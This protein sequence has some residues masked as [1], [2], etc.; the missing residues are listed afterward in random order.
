MGWFVR[1]VRNKTKVFLPAPLGRA[2]A[3]AMQKHLNGFGWDTKVVQVE[4]K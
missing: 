4:S 2:E 1:A 3:L